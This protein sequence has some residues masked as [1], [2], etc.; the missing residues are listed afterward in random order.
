MSFVDIVFLHNI[1]DVTLTLLKIITMNKTL[2]DKVAIITGAG[3]GIGKAI[4]L[5]YAEAGATVICVARTLTEIEQTVNEI[6]ALGGK[7]LAI[8]TDVTDLSAVQTMMQMA[9]KTFGGLDIL[10]FAAGA[11]YEDKAVA[12]SDPELWQAT[13][14]VNLIAPYY[15]AKTIVPYLKKR[16]GGKIIMIGSGLGHKGKAGSSAYACAKSGLWM[17]TRVLAQEVWQDNISV[18]ELIPGPV[19]TALAA[20]LITP[21]KKPKIT[22]EWLKSPEDVVPLALFLAEQPLIST[23]AQ[24]F[25]LMRRD[26]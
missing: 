18:N 2:A 10:V 6:E 4:A 9:A 7:A 22:S 11:Y 14:S 25:S 5:G 23:T 21:T 24:S 8:Q 17:L 15:S 20:N 19:K 12:E 26:D 13:L 3:R 1:R 16:G